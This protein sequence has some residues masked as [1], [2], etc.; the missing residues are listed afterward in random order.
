MKQSFLFSYITLSFFISC[1]TKPNEQPA[2]PGR[3]NIFKM[4]YVLTDD[5]S[6]GYG[7]EIFDNGKKIIT[8][9]Y[10]PGIAGQNTFTDKK[11][12]AAVAE[13]VIKKIEK[14]EFPPGVSTAELDSL[15]AVSRSN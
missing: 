3:E 2:N 15:L 10:M 13:F 9:P 8:Q 5:A 7:Y 1:S 6:G 12:A 11:S 14:S 4:T